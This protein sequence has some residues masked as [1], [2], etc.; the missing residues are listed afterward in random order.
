M[1]IKNS[2]MVC[3]KCGKA[4]PYY[5]YYADVCMEL[6]KFEYCYEC[7]QKILIAMGIKEE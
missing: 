3:D 7:Y 5:E 2:E 6:R 1:S 4:I